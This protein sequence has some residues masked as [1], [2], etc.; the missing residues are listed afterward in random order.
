[1]VFHEM[2]SVAV[3][4]LKVTRLILWSG[5]DESM[6]ISFIFDALIMVTHVKPPSGSLSFCV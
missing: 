1:M 3:G 2:I 4:F 5:K 6:Q